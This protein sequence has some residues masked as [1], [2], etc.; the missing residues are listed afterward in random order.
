MK[1]PSLFLPDFFSIK[2][3]NALNVSPT[4]QKGVYHLKL[5]GKA[6]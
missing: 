5:I 3:N 1:D 2:N 6:A 4:L